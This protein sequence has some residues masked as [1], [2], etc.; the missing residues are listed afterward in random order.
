MQPSITVK[1][2]FPWRPELSVGVE[3][4]D[5]QHKKL[6]AIIN[7]LNQ[8]MSS[9][10]GQQVLGDVLGR[11]IS[12]TKTH[13]AGEEQMLAR[14]KYG[15]LEAHKLEHAKLIRS[16]TNLQADFASGRVGMTIA[17]MKFLTDWLQGHILSIDKKYSSHVNAQGIR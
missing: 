9:G 14:A 13:F 3:S 5:V 8:A 12:Y 17:V 2:V 6:I 11:L 15:D 1:D 4:I 10:K 7:E 16:V